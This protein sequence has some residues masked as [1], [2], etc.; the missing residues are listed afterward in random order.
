MIGHSC[1]LLAISCG[2]SSS[3]TGPAWAGSNAT[4]PTGSISTIGVALAEEPQPPPPLPPPHPHPLAMIF[5]SELLPNDL[6]TTPQVPDR[7]T[8]DVHQAGEREQH[9][10]GQAQQH[11]KLVDQA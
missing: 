9:E 6:I 10:Q 5:S 3:A 8:D 1:S 7:R 2:A 11:V 4:A